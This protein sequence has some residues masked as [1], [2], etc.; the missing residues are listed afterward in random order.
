MSGLLEG[1]LLTRSPLRRE[2][3]FAKTW[4]S[5]VIRLTMP[6]ARLRNIA[7]WKRRPWMRSR[8]G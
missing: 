4:T 3:P 6:T 2:E 5:S 7:A 8:L 1:K